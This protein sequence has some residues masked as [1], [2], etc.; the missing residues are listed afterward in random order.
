MIN[1]DKFI[2]ALDFPCLNQ[3]ALDYVRKIS[4]HVGMIKIGL[5][6]FTAEGPSFL[7][8]CPI[9]VFL[10]LKLHDI[11]ETVAG[12]VT[13]AGQYGV[14][15]LTVHASGGEEMLQAAVAAAKPFNLEI[16][17][18]IHL[19]SLDDSCFK[20]FGINPDHFKT[21]LIYSARR[22]GIT[23]FISSSKDLVNFIVQ[24]NH[25]DKFIVPGTRMTNLYNGSQKHIVTPASAVKNGANYVVLGRELR[26]SVNPVELLQQ[27]DTDIIET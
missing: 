26:D 17:A 2:A 5:Q 9:P 7:K 15:F 14:K 23:H 11:P 20:R 4:P 3:V 1:K 8:S 13:S 12:A 27:I 16:L 21:E 18:V 6:L 24:T 25:T 22:S 19:T 10:D